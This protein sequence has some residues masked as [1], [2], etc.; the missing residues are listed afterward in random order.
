M[1]NFSNKIYELQ[2]ENDALILRIKILEEEIEKSK[3]IKDKSLRKRTAKELNIRTV[4]SMSGKSGL[5]SSLA[6][7][8]K[9]NKSLESNVESHFQKSRI[10]NKISEIAPFGIAVFQKTGECIFFNEA[11]LA[12]LGLVEEDVNGHKLRDIKLFSNCGI[13]K[14]AED[15]LFNGGVKYKEIFISGSSN[16]SVWVDAYF[17][18]FISREET[19]LL[20]TLHEV[21]GRKES[22]EKLRHYADTLYEVNETRN[23]FFSILSH[24]LK[25]PF[26]GLLGVSKL[27]HEEYDSLTIEDIKC[28]NELQFAAIKNLYNL[29]ENLLQWSGLQLGRSNFHPVR[30]NLKEQINNLIELLK[31]N[32]HEKEIFITNTAAEDIYIKADKNMF[33]SIVQNLLSNA[34]KFTDKK[35]KIIIGGTPAEDFVRV[36]IDDTGIGIKQDDLQKLFN[37][38]KHYSTR[39]TRNESGTGFGLILTKELVEK[40]GGKIWVES[41]PNKGTRFIFSIPVSR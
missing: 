16:K 8:Y 37:I 36:S 3:S 40:H 22:E 17:S 38:D 34:I 19:Y 27:L 18:R 6:L 7:S 11:L 32:A 28:Y 31:I 20:I 39:G 35:G 4:R 26:L 30:M 23:K 12:A 25:S 21:T 41:K 13:S 29:I 14:I 1:K 15:V 9:M 2:S 10:S 5:L 24:D 33:N